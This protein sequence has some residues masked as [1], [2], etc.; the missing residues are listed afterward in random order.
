MCL[1]EGIP[2]LDR[3][4]LLMSLSVHTNLMLHFC[5]IS[6]PA[7]KPVSVYADTCCTARTPTY[8]PYIDVVSP[9][10]GVALGGNGHAAKSCDEIGRVAA[11]F[12]RTGAWDSAI[13]QEKLRCRM[14]E[15]TANL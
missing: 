1:I 5:M 9:R 8:A 12:I 3:P 7:F 4:S 2:R 10:L 13:P 6:F 15:P 11:T 14:K